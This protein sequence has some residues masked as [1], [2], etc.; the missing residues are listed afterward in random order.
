MG[1]IQSGSKTSDYQENSPH[2]DQQKQETTE[3][4]GYIESVIYIVDRYL[5]PPKE[6]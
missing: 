3:T 6:P 5:Q 1:T 4:T 2:V